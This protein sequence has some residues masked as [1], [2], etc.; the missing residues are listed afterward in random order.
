MAEHREECE[1][2]KQAVLNYA[3]A[4]YEVNPR[5]I[6]ESVHPKVQK[7]GYAPKKDISAQQRGL[8]GPLFISVG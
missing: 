4:I 6:D 3:L 7:V 2:I 1:A 5:L 8:R